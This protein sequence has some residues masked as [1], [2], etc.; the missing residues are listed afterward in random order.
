[1][2]TVFGLLLLVTLS[3]STAL[4][5]LVHS[6]NPDPGLP[7]FLTRPIMGSTF[8]SQSQ[9]MAAQPGQHRWS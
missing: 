4:P 9:R 2:K 1:M 5:A 6:Q 7:Q 8:C 3:I